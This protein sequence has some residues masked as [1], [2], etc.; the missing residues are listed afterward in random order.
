[1]PQPPAAVSHRANR[2]DA[3]RAHLAQRPELA[4]APVQ[5]EERPAKCPPSTI[6]PARIVVTLQVKPGLARRTRHVQRVGGPAP[7]GNPPR[8]ARQD[9]LDVVEPAGT[10]TLP[11]GRVDADVIG[12]H[13][14]SGLLAGQSHCDAGAC[15]GVAARAGAAGRRSSS[16]RTARITISTLM[17]VMQRRSIGHSGNWHGPHST[18]AWSLISPA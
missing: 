12:V 5:A 2:R 6:P 8:H 11:I 10:Q 15:S 18:G 14:A 3:Q 16:S 17:P 7:G 1:M 13:H 9:R 4:L